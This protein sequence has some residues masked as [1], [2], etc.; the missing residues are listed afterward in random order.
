M[1]VQLDPVLLEVLA[2]PAEHHAPLVVGSPG[3]P[4]A[5]A[6]TCTECGRVYPIRDGIPVLLLDEAIAGPGVGFDG[7][8][9]GRAS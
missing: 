6:L 5:D 7:D 2:C 8:G 9:G 3:D 1:S 4:A